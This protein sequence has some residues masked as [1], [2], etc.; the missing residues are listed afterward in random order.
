MSPIRTFAA[1]V[2]AAALVI[3]ATAVP[4][5]AHD[6]L[7]SS[8]PAADARLDVPPKEVTMVFSGELLVLDDSDAGAR[9]AVVDAAGKDWIDGDIVVNGDT[10]TIPL[11]PAMPE[12]GYQVRWQVVSEDG[13]PIAGVIPFTIGD[14]KP[15][16]TDSPASASPSPAAVDAQDEGAAAGPPRALFIGLG[17][18]VIAAAAYVLYLVIRRKKKAAASTG[19][20]EEL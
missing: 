16:T 11:D 9:A 4:A 8:D 12:A 14:A 5:S 20:A 17:G 3:L 19:A 6:E 1:G 15:M 13:H 2:A 10:V 7:I 18:A